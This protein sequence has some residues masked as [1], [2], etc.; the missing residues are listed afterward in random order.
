MVCVPRT[1]IYA[2]NGKLAK[3]LEG[4]QSAAEF[5]RALAPLLAKR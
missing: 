1:Y 2:R 3:V 4:E 5:E